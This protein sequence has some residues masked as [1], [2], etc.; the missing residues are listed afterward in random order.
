MHGDEERVESEPARLPERECQSGQSPL[1]IA[2]L[3]A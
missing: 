1:D 3:I 2:D